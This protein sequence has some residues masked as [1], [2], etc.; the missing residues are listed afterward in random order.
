ME[1]QS[2][3]AMEEHHLQSRTAMEH[4]H[5]HQQATEQQSSTSTV[6]H[7]HQQATEQQSSTSTVRHQQAM[8]R[9]VH[10]L[11][12]Q[13]TEKQSSTSTVHHQQTMEQ[14]SST[15]TVCHLHHH[16]GG[17]KQH[18]PP[19]AKQHTGPPPSS[20]T[21]T[22]RPRR[23]GPPPPPPA[24]EHTGLPPSS[25]T[26]TWWPRPAHDTITWQPGL[27]VFHTFSSPPPPGPLSIASPL[28]SSSSAAA[29]A[30]AAFVTPGLLA[31]S[32]VLFLL[33]MVAIVTGIWILVKGR[34]K[35]ANDILVRYVGSS[36]L[37]GSSS[38][39]QREY[40]V[41]L[42]KIEDAE[43]R[44]KLDSFVQERS[45]QQLR[46]SQLNAST[47]VARPPLARPPKQLP[48][49]AFLKMNPIYGAATDSVDDRLMPSLG[50]DPPAAIHGVDEHK[51]EQALD[52]VSCRG[53]VFEPGD[54]FVVRLAAAAEKRAEMEKHMQRII[55][56]G[57]R[58]PSNK[59]SQRIRE[60]ENL[61]KPVV[62]AN[63]SANSGGSH[64]AARVHDS[65]AKAKAGPW[66]SIKIITDGEVW[67][68]LK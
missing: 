7:L 37:L 34:R 6:C 4:H 68:H 31:A 38:G 46:P 15:S 24:K 1:Q 51:K 54:A 32:I 65:D 26:T 52:P 48:P 57:M 47:K 13:A 55:E 49:L 33:A 66:Y 56:F 28:G 18:P 22:W 9:T 45:K 43:L 60:V 25:G 20:G 19:P 11:H 3:T 41:P 17:A 29:A 59:H 63:H 44:D 62:E 42:S 39:S 53:T 10:H 40:L 58:R 35:K 14:Q 21:T 27:P 23:F 5:L 16:G 67:R 2:S 50:R 8:E 64:L 36:H 30:A 12:Q 61:E